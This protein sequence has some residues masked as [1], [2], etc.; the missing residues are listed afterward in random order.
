MSVTGIA[1]ATP[2]FRSR[3][4]EGLAPRDRQIVLA[5][6]NELHFRANSVVV[7]QSDPADHMFVLTNGRARHF[8]MTEQGQKLS[9]YWLTPGEAFGGAALVSRPSPYIVSTETVKDSCVLAWDRK[10]LRRLVTRYPILIDNT[11]LIGYDHF[12]WYVASHKALSCQTA[13]QR[14]GQVLV[15]AAQ[16]IGK[17]V[18]DGIEV[19]VTN[20][21][22]ASAANVTPFTVSRA[23]NE[24]QRNHIVKKLRGKVLLRSP[25]R[26]SPA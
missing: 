7:H 18:P 13:R 24:W 8:Y 17:K 9:L 6:G 26:L 22:L 3:F 23:L 14:L 5:A 15:S 20:E 10:T 4:L 16:I 19:D 2:A 21:E 12:D 25:E 1:S 11:F